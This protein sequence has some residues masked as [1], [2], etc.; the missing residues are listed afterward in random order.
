MMMLPFRLL[1]RIWIVSRNC[2][3][4]YTI[5]FDKGI[6]RRLDKDAAAP[7]WLLHL[8]RTDWACPGEEADNR[9]KWWLLPERY[10]PLLLSLLCV[11]SSNVA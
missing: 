4:P 5:F 1:F 2:C 8:P 3:V 11:F 6:A 9:N 7:Y 10:H